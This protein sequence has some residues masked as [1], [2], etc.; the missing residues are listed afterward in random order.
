MLVESE[1]ALHGLV[2]AVDVLNGRLTVQEYIAESA[3]TDLRVL[4]IGGR[5]I[6]AMK[7]IAPKGDFRANLHQGGNAEGVELN[8]ELREIAE[9]TAKALGLGIAGVDLMPTSK[10]Y[11]VIEANGSPGIKGLQSVSDVD[12]AAEI[13]NYL[14]ANV[15][16]AP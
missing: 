3:G 8:D 6:A 2:D 7:R 4:V 11:I 16:P 15:P 10:G 12:I 1:A 13:V 5:A 9:R 14:A